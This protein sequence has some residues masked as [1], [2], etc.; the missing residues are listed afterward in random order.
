MDN[1]E[2][3]A[4]QL[5]MRGHAS[6]DELLHASFGEWPPKGLDIV[7]ENAQRVNLTTSLHRFH[8]MGPD[9]KQPPW[10][11]RLF[12]FIRVGGYARIAGGRDIYVNKPMALLGGTIGTIGHEMAHILQGDH[13]Y[14]ARDIMG[15]DALA[16]VLPKQDALSNIIINEAM[17][18]AFQPGF[19]RRIMNAVTN[20]TGLGIDYLKSGI[21]IQA[22][23]QEALIEG[24][25]KWERMPQN[26]TDFFFAMRS[27]G[28]KLTPDLTKVMDIHPDR[29]ELEKAFPKSKSIF[30]MKSQ[31]VSDIEEVQ[32]N[33]TPEGKKHFWNHIMPRLYADLIEMYGDRHGRERMGMGP[34][35]THAYRTSHE[36]DLKTLGGQPWSY[37]HTE[38]A[39]HYAYVRLDT[40]ANGDEERLLKALDNQYIGVTFSDSKKP[41]D[42]RYLFVNGER[43]MQAFKNVMG[44]K[45]PEPPAQTQAPSAQASARKTLF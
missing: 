15:K 35:E 30:S 29:E 38:Q 33:L 36:N 16:V 12:E 27:L 24:Y 3:L 31:F 42:A 25:P 41:G 8:S 22:R 13:S 44:D 11:K 6:V 34:N 40:L 19:M 28:F 17:T 18:E 9:G 7:H 43:N 32:A 21:E 2:K 26:N 4:N 14:R 39:G 23:L 1:R 20:V 10:Y 5:L 45:V 37:A